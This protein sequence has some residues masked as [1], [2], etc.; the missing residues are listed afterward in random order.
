MFFELSLIPLIFMI[1]GWGYQVE[2]VQAAFYLI[3]YTVLGSLPLLVVFIY[4]FQINS[5]LW[6]GF[7][8]TVNP[9][10][11]LTISY[12][13]VLVSLRLLVK[14][15]IYGLHLWLPKAHVEAPVAGSI[16]LAA[17]LLKLR[18]YGFYRLLFFF[19]VFVGAFH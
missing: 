11:S 15:P 17:I 4:L 3:I 14:L 5:L 13:V 18:A 8:V 6:L 2:R 16:V 12:I 10:Q 7:T 1:F 19:R 9:S